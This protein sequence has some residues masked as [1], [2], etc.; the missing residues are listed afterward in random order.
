MAGAAAMMLLAMG[1]WAQGTVKVYPAPAGEP[2][3]KMY[4]VSVGGQNAPVYNAKVCSVNAAGNS[5]EAAWVHGVAGFAQ[6]DIDGDVE[7]KIT[8][9]EK[10][11]TAKVLPT[12]R[13]IMAQIAGNTITFR[14][15]KPDQL[16]VDVN[17]DWSNS[18]HLFANPMETDIPNL[19]DPNL[20]Y[21]GPGLHAIEPMHITSGKTIYVAGGAVVYG[22]L[23]AGVSAD[24]AG[25]AIFG[26]DGSN[27]TLRGRG[28]IDGSLL[29]PHKYNLMTEHGSNIKVEGVVLRDAGS[30]NMP[31]RDSN[32]VD[33][34]NVKLIAYRV[35]SD[36]ID[37]INSQNV[38]I[39]N[40]F[41]RTFDDLVV[42]KTSKE[43]GQETKDVLVQHVV[44]WNEKAHALHLGS[45]IKEGIENVHF[46]DS[47]IIHD[48]GHDWLLRILDGDKGASRNI[49][50][51]NIRVE[52]CERLISLWIGQHAKYNGPGR[53]H[54]DDVVF[55]N[56]QS[57]KPE[58]DHGIQLV[59]FDA[60][61]AIHGALFDNVKIAGK[62]LNSQEI[63]ANSFVSGVV[64]KP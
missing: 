10:V 15:A 44:L 24:A 31:L 34:S 28:I 48:K 49:V 51:D 61:H 47:D 9:S 5:D 33:I 29:P 25:H 4:V 54:I 1:A 8:Y 59:G 60:E 26:L 50:W 53:G 11:K 43:G 58:Q 62:P 35:N 6:F 40:S 57:A 12:S 27:I 21:F 64:V 32:H 18:L 55:R 13:G 23:P 17:G 36:G 45:E 2:L 30:F 14:I 22:R 7:V 46:T 19:K 63:E 37:V 20:I 16:T 56:I 3:S 38:T 52:E 41:L 42:M 39:S